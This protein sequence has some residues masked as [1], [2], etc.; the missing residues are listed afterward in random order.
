MKFLKKLG[1]QLLSEFVVVISCDLALANLRRRRF[2][3]VMKQCRPHKHPGIAAFVA[4]AGCM[5]QN[6]HGMIPY[7]SFRMVLR[8][9]FHLG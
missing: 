1:C 3:Q 7:I 9:L 5:I 6:H 4:F 8:G 2:A